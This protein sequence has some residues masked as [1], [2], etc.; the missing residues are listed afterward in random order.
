MGQ[1]I[2]MPKTL[3]KIWANATVTAAE[4]PVTSAASMAVIVVPKFAPRVMGK[5]WRRVRMPAPASGTAK[6]VVI[7]LL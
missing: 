5:I 1:M 2:M 3:K 6:D 4:F 7:E